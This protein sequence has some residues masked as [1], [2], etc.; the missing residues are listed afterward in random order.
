[1]AFMKADC[2]FATKN[3]YLILSFSGFWGFLKEI[4]G[5]FYEDS[6]KAQDSSLIYT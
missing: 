1:M 4:Y 3:P 5:S 6:W 2:Y